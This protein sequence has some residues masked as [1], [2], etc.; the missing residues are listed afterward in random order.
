MLQR[1][2]LGVAVVVED[3]ERNRMVKAYSKKGCG[4]NIEVKLSSYVLLNVR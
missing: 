1:A 2:V 3:V 4:G